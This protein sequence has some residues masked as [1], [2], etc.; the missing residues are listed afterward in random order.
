M[1]IVFFGTPEFAVEALKEIVA[2]NHKVVA[3][4]TAPDSL[5]GRGRNQLIESEVKK[6]ALAHTIPILQP[7]KLRDKTFINA[8]QEL[9]ADIYVV[10]AFRML[11]EQVWNMPPLGTINAH[12]S[13]LPKY[14]GAAPIHW[15]VING[16]IET[17]VT[18]FKLKHKIDTGDIILK[19]KMSIGINDT[20]G[21][22]YHK[23]MHLGA[24]TLVKALDLIESGQV[25]FE[26]QNEGEA[27]PAPK[28]FHENASIDPH[29]SSG[30]IHNLVRG[31]N[32][33]P[34][35]WLLSDGIK[36]FIHR[37]R[38]TA[39]P[40]NFKN[41]EVGKFFKSKNELFLRTKDGALTILE[42]Q[43]EGK[44]KMTG[45]EFATRLK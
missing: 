36:Y 15:A 40:H 18:I 9:K 2:S 19:A 1:R 39:P 17:G 33:N 5:G 11:P 24:Q 3:V 32:P 42:I 12:G 10:V 44:R 8:L 34:S 20:T 21:E 29:L 38:L 35:A 43:P 7:E 25:F 23:L 4:V 45:A 41:Y 31:L 16:E 22:V 27:S 30:Q 6:Y 28:L 37:T 14:R 13:L 26:A